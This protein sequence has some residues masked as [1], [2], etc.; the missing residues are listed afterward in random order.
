MNEGLLQWFTACVLVAGSWSVLAGNDGTLELEVQPAIVPEL[1]A[2]TAHF[3]KKIYKVGERVYSAVG[4]NISNVIMIEGHDSIVIVDAGLSPETTAEVLTEFRKITSKPIAAII[5]SHFH[6]DHIDGVR[7]LV[8]EAQIER[9]GVRIIAHQSFMSH[10]ADE[11]H[12]LGPILAARGGYTFG[13]MLEPPDRE[14]MNAGIGP[15]PVGGR[16]G[17]FIPPNEFVDSVLETEIAGIALQIFHVPSEAPDELAIFLPEERILIDTEVL[18]GPTFPNI[19][20]LRGTKFRDPAV[21]VESIDKLRALDAEHLVPTHGQPTSGAENVSQVLTK[22]RDGIQYVLDQS[23]RWMNRGADAEELVDKVKLPAH[24]ADFAPYL[25]QYYGTVEQ[26]VRAIYVGYLGWFNGDPVTLRPTSPAERSRKFLALLGG[27]EEALK[28][29]IEA[30]HGEEFQWAA[31]LVSLILDS[32]PAHTDAKNLKAASFRQLAYRSMNIN[33]RNWYLTS[34]MEL[35]GTLGSK[36]AAVNMRS[37]FLPPDIARAL[38]AR[39]TLKSWTSRLKAEDTLDSQVSVEFT[40]TDEQAEV[41]TLE[42][43]R[44]VCRFRVGQDVDPSV[45]IVLD[46]DALNSLVSGAETP[47]TLIGRG[48]IEVAGDPSEFLRFTA[49]FEDPWSNVPAVALR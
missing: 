49:F 43:D 2:H 41:Y 47:Q 14:G 8:D 15:L 17:T 35:E 31:E 19:Y 37:V 25:R 36:F 5:Y 29:A 46:K 40:I 3:E 45:R 44:G 6:H 23:I 33:W 11:S 9:D 27:E 34:A 21:W 20:S 12:L 18:Q 16:P 28:A 26:A 32:N 39:V 24:L 38:P 30:Y 7:G 22:T 1:Q 48:Q 10:L 42:V 13:F 4:W